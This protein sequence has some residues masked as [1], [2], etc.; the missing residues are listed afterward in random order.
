MFQD[1]QSE[2]N[3]K[4]PTANKFGYFVQFEIFLNSS[5]TKQ[6]YTNVLIF[7]LFSIDQ[8]QKQK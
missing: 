1:S 5:S 7:L 3:S 4:I 8:S 6:L 2:E